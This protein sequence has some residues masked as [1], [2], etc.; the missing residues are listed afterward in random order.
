MRSLFKFLRLYKKYIYINIK[1]ITTYRSSFILGMIGQWFNYGAMILTLYVLILNFNNLDGWTSKEIL[2]LYSFNLIAYAIAASILFNPCRTLGQK[3]V[4]GEFDASL[5]K[6]ISPL[7]YEIL[8]GFSF[9]YISH[10]LFSFFILA[11]VMPKL[12]ICLNIN[13]LIISL[14]M[15]ISAVMVQVSLLLIGASLSF[16]I[17]GKNTL[18][19]QLFSTMKIATKYPITI[20]PNMIQVI[21]TFVLPGAFMNFYPA[22]VI[23]GKAEASPFGKVIPYCSPIVGV[24]MMIISLIIWNKGVKQYQSSGT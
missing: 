22:I 23:L 24:I 2:F 21:L 19:G 1:S 20:Y 14:L 12:N 18:S 4:I 16:W 11:C 7:K 5:T 13:W 10:L 8:T 3:L 6:P 17:F 15:L 9:G